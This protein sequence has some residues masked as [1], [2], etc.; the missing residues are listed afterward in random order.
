MKAIPAIWMRGGTSKGLYFDQ[1]DLPA[2][3]A[4][5]DR[6][7]LAAMGSPDDRQIDGVGGATP[8]TS[9]VCMVSP[10][11]HPDADVDYFFAQVIIGKPIVDTSPTC[12]N[13]LSGI[14]PFAIE[15]G[16]VKAQ[17]GQTRVRINVVNIGGLVEAVVQTPG[18]KVEYEGDVRIDGV[19]GSAAPIT[20]NVLKC[21]GS[22]TSGLLPTGNAVDEIDGLRVS[23]VDAAMPMMLVKAADIGKTG[24]ETPKELDADRDMFRRLEA[25]RRIA[26]E[27]MGLG[28]VS[29]KVVPKIGIVAPPRSGGSISDRYLVPDK[30][31][32]AH[33]ATGS[34]CVACAAIV[35]GTVANEV[36]TASLEADREQVVRIEHPAGFIDVTLRARPSNSDGL[37]LLS[38]GLVRTARLLFDGA[39]MIPGHLLQT[40]RAA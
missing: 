3:P 18:G 10:S 12:G 31:H 20:L 9:K 33:A 4:M 14:G 24:Y 22:R 26:G 36:S 40:E 6:V 27:R 37:E 28:D 19:P 29:D 38:A 15:R 25:V 2:D 32:E 23:C 30:A 13:L 16:M 11:S 17:D 7:L 21:V 35:P 39:V 34:I 1:R 8:L 5:R